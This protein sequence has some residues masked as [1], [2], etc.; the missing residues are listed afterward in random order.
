VNGYIDH[1]HIGTTGNHGAITDLHTLQIP[2]EHAKPR[3]FI[4]FHSHC[5]VTA[6]NNGDSSA[7]VLTPLPAG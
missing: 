7:S 6:L 5:F 3:S 4:A 2:T 1:L